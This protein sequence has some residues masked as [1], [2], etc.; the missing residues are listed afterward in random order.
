MGN[1]WIGLGCQID[2]STTAIV[3]TVE[4]V[5]KDFHLDLSL[6]IGLGTVDRKAPHQEILQVCQIKR[7]QLQ[8]FSAAELA[9]VTVPHPSITTTVQ[10]GTP[11]VAEG[12]ALLAAGSGGHLLVTKQIYWQTGKALTIAV[13]RATNTDKMSC[14]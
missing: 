9:I 3:Q 10:I 6:V 5:F 11:T 4:Q 12:A 14:C 13:A 7:W 2:T 8:F 1:L